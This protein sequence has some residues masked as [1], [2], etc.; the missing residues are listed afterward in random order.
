[1]R[2]DLLQFAEG[3]RV[4][5][6]ERGAGGAV[7]VQ[8]RETGRVAWLEALAYGGEEAGGWA[9]HRCVVVE[10]VEMVGGDEL[11]LMDVAGAPRHWPMGV[12]QPEELGG[13]GWASW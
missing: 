13:R 3:G 4:E 7:G 10:G 12:Q 1:M 8:A 5:V 6:D 9:E 2:G 11:S